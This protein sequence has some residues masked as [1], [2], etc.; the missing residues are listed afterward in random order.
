[1]EVSGPIPAEPP[2]A[3]AAHA[4]QWE[5]VTGAALPSLRLRHAGSCDAD[6]RTTRLGGL[7]LLLP[8]SKWPTTGDGTPLALIAQLHCGEVNAAYGSQVLPAGMLLSFFYEVEEQAWGYDPKHAPYSRVIA[9]DA[10]AAVATPVPEDVTVFPSFAM[11]AARV[12][13]VPESDETRVEGL[14]AD[15][16]VYGSASAE[17]YDAFEVDAA[18]EA[19]PQHRVFGWPDL[20]QNPMQL[21]CQLAANGIYVGDSKGYRSRKAQRLLSGATDWIL[22]C[23][24]DTDD[25]VGWMWGDVGTLYFWIRRQDL[26]AADFTRTWTILQCT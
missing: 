16:T 23:Q 14:W 19:G 13:T 15:R 26:A 10:A 8:G 9:T 7:P 12:L 11:T 22:L 1:M 21:H 24:I 25:D 2:P 4:A 5:A 18:S 3:A 20:I 6:A 17:L